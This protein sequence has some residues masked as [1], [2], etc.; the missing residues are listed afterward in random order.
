MHG[1]SR[2]GNTEKHGTW[3]RALLFSSVIFCI[4]LCISVAWAR[5]A[6]AQQ[7][8]SFTAIPPR[9]EIK[10]KPGQFVTETVKFRNEGDSTVG[11]VAFPQDFIV[12]DTAGTPLFVSER[13]S[14]RWSAASW[15]SLSPYRFSVPPKGTIQVTLNANVPLDAMPGGHYAGI[16]YQA[17]E[18]PIPRPG[19]TTT[20]GGGT[21]VAQTIGTLVYFTVEGPITERAIVKRFEAPRFLEFGPVPFTTEILNRSDIH[22][23][24]KGQITV[25][26][27]L[28]KVSTTLPLD[29][30]NIFPGA[31]F[32][33]TNTWETKYLVGRY[34]ADLLAT[35][36]SGQALEATLYFWVFP[37]RIALAVVLVIVII[38][39]IILLIRRRKRIK[40][41]EEE[42]EEAKEEAEETK[43]SS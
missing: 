23:T 40:E 34:R 28:G 5:S 10:V 25:R 27:I 9:L 19:A 13:V 16:L 38:I 26:N 21:G 18:I 7:V 8:Q 6:R 39:L 31:S 14:G 1:K 4:L 36:R 2:I 32:I 41:L 20:V 15:I 29:E 11:L 3:F 43:K 12:T 33:Y 42:L 37:V 24:P 22:I 30:R 35:Y 17:A